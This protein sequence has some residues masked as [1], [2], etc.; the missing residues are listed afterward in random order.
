[1]LFYGKSEMACTAAD[2]QRG[3]T[4]AAEALPPQTPQAKTFKLK[5]SVR[6]HAWRIPG[7]NR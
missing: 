4:T 3:E 1:M 5:F 2:G 7:A 6:K